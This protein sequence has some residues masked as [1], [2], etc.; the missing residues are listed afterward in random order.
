[1]TGSINKKL[2]LVKISISFGHDI[3]GK[4]NLKQKEKVQI[5]HRSYGWD[6]PRHDGGIGLTQ[7][8]AAVQLQN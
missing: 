5:M 1:M 7:P 3:T 6:I 2:I 8:A 4:I